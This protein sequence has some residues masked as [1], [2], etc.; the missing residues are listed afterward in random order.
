M[1]L[2]E[3]LERYSDRVSTRRWVWALTVAVTL[4]AAGLCVTY[5]KLLNLERAQAFTTAISASVR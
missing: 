2:E 4:L 5:N 3:L 1:N